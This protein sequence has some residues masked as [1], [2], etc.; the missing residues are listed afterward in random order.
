MSQHIN[1]ETAHSVVAAI[2]QIKFEEYDNIQGVMEQFRHIRL[3]E[4]YVLDAFKVGGFLGSNFQLYARHKDANQEFE[5]T[6]VEIDD[7][8]Y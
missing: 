4:G 1:A 2:K 5:C 7:E 3:R 6:Q 8:I